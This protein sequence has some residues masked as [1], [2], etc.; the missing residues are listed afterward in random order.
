MKKTK[1]NN[2]YNFISV[3][4]VS[5][6]ILLVGLLLKFTMQVKL[7]SITKVLFTYIRP[8][9]K[10]EINLFSHEQNYCWLIKTPSWLNSDYENFS[11]LK[12]FENGIPLSH[13]HANHNDIRELGNG[14]YSHWGSAIFFSTSDNS[15]P[16]TNNRRYEI[17]E[18]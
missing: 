7:P 18:E 17:R 8:K 5:I 16:N 2:N 10:K 14:R 6:Y 4:F 12:I 13:P 1:F 15:D 3:F 11:K 9:Y